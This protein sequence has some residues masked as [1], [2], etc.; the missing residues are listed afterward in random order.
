MRSWHAV[1]CSAWQCHIIHQWPWSWV[2][3]TCMH[4]SRKHMVNS[5]C[6]MAEQMHNLYPSGL[7]NHS[8]AKICLIILHS[9]HRDNT[10][11]SLRHPGIGIRRFFVDN[12]NYDRTDFFTPCS[13]TQDNNNS[14]YPTCCTSTVYTVGA[15]SLVPRPTIDDLH[16]LTLQREHMTCS[17]VA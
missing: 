2:I 6:G 3:V 12:H 13:C 8:K 11:N 14:T 10:N 1:Q 16:L 5:R 17:R 15:S 9:W 7:I 4:M